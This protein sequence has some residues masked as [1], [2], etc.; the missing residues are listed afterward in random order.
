MKT[1]TFK[2]DEPDGV[3]KQC[4]DWERAN[5]HIHVVTKHPVVVEMANVRP[6]RKLALPTYTMQIDYRD[7][8]AP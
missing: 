7:Q 1:I 5:P 3:T 4:A 8:R 2:G 6:T